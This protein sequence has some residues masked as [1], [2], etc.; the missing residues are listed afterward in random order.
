LGAWGVWRAGGRGL[1]LAWGG[2]AGA[3]AGLL[4]SATLACAF[5]LLE[6]PAHTA[7][8]LFGSPA[9]LLYVPLWSLLAIFSWGLLGAGLFLFC[10]LVPSLRRLLVVPSQLLLAQMFRSCGLRNLAESWT[11][12]G[13]GK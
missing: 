13:G 11:P 7:W 1:D 8:A 10:S 9:G 2:L 5:L 3:V 12:P 4:A 6:L